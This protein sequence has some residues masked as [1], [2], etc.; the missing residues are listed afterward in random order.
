VLGHIYRGNSY[1]EVFI[2]HSFEVVFIPGAIFPTNDPEDNSSF[3][4]TLKTIKL[5]LLS[6][7]YIF[8]TADL[9][10]KYGTLNP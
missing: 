6:L 5:R 4:G 1:E 2:S 7:Y 8:I 3:I 9:T 10:P